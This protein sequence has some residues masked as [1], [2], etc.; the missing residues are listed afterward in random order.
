MEKFDDNAGVELIKYV[1]S[2]LSIPSLIQS[3]DPS[4]ADKARSVGADFIDKNS[5][6]LSQDISDFIHLKLGFGDFIF[7]N[8]RGRKIATAHNLKEFYNCIKEVEAEIAFIPCQKK[9]NKYL[10]YGE[11][12]N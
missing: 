6:T 4:N 1:Q 11:R 3:S 7:K 9:W 5:E 10:A 2:V 12:R 8:S